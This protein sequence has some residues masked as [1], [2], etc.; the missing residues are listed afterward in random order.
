[1]INAI[2]FG[3]IVIATLI[4]MNSIE[5]PVYVQTP[6]PGAVIF[7]PAPATGSDTYLGS[8]TGTP[9]TYWNISTQP[10]PSG[11]VVMSSK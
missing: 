7:D 6:Q 9:G 10:P 2:I 4:F 3:G 1:M 5:K 8:I 11:M